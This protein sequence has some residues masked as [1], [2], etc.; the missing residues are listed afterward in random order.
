VPFWV[1]V[2]L[3][4]VAIDFGKYAAHWLLHR[5]DRLWQFHKAHHSSLELD[6]MATFRSHL[7]E[8]GLRRL[9]APTL[10]IVAGAPA[11]AV[12]VAAGIFF[13]WAMLNHAN[14]RLPLWPIESVLVTPRLHRVH[15]VPATTERN[16]GTVF[17]CWD[18]LRGT[19]VVADPS[20]TASFGLPLERETYP[21]SWG[22]QL[23]APSRVTFIS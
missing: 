19:F 10:L 6:V 11:G 1:Q 8:Q 21:Q 9:L 22:R 3:A 16:L 13:V 12:G 7:V 15:H 5:S 18:R 14:L 20:P 17:T 2:L 4:L 23:V